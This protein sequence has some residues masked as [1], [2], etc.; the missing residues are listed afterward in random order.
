MNF[1]LFRSLRTGALLALL[2][3]LASSSTLTNWAGHLPAGNAPAA[4]PLQGAKPDPAVIAQFG[5][6]NNATLQSL[7]N[8]KGKQMTAVSDR[9]GDYGFTVVDS[10]IIN[11]F[12]TPDGHVYFTRG[13][14]AYFNNE[15]QFAGVLGHELGHITA[16]HGKKQQTRSTIASILLGVGSAVSPNL[17]GKLA[18]P[19]STGIG[20]VF[21]KYGRD[22]E[23]EADGLGVKYSTKIG[24]DAAQMA[25]FFLTLQRTEAQSGAG[26]VPT[27]LS[28]HPNSADRYT[29]VKG[30]AA[31]AR[32]SVGNRTLAV[33]RNQYLRSIE[34]LNYGEDPRQGF[35]ESGVFYHPDLK[36]HFPIPSGWKSQNSPEQFQMAEPNGKALLIF[37]GVPG[38][39]LDAAG[40][41]LAKQIGL[42]SANAQKTTINGF[43]ALTFEGDQTAS[44]QSSATPA[45]VLA[46]LIQ[47]GQ[48]VYA[49]VGLATAASF[50]TYSP[51][52]SQT[53]QG[54]GRLTDASKL[55]RQ[56][57]HVRIK[58]AAA[59]T[60]LASAFAANG[61]PSK[62]YEELAIL[63]G[64]KTT[65][66]LPKGT[67]YKVVGK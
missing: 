33:N 40:Q 60:T 63:N 35:V 4:R 12:A 9:P 30:L 25:D 34:G 18:Q 41:N 7:I 31:Q 23:N 44:D 62:R 57:E 56:P 55:N 14:M 54:F 21:L 50:A 67:L 1:S 3:P 43:P 58:T 2:V 61:I 17:V 47:D 59:N 32:Q 65:D 37:L 13:I 8:A 29:R 16:Q 19:L 27:F 28:T 36:F 5:L 39:S 52:F 45:H 38:T 10:P 66:Q 51:Q 6:Y 24:Y 42:T 64:M 11:A 22:D 20:V 53:A 15:A 26:G 46:Q 48:S 49:F